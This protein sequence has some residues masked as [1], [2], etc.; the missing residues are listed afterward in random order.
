MRKPFSNWAK[1]CRFTFYQRVRR[2]KFIVITALVGLIILLAISLPII[3]TAQPDDED[4]KNEYLEEVSS[5]LFDNET[6]WKVSAE[7]LVPFFAVD[8]TLR[9]LTAKDM[10]GSK[11][12]LAKAAGASEKTLAIRLEQDG[13]NYSLI[14]I[15]PH[16]TNISEDTASAI[17]NAMAPYVHQLLIADSGASQVA[18]VLAQLEVSGSTEVAGEEMSLAA[19]MVKQFLPML[20]GLFMYMMLIL[21][22]QDLSQEVSSEKTSKL[23]ET[24]LTSVHPYA[25]V[26]GKVVAV[27]LVAVLQSMVW[28]GCILLGIFGGSFLATK[29]YPDGGSIITVVIEFIRTNIGKSAFSIPAIIMAVVIFLLGVLLFFCFAAMAGSMVSK[30]EDTASVQPLFVWPILICWMVPYFASMSGNEGVLAVCRYIPFTAPFCLPVDL[31]IGT[32][33]YLP[34]F[35][36]LVLILLTACAL[37]W[38]A[39]R[40]YKGMALYIGQKFSLKVVWGVIRGK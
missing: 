35:V 34:G 33:G 27:F 32:T 7:D 5:I 17:G 16:E 18:I 31:I 36:T 1:V 26:L 6:E 25:L 3:F 2:G 9:G 4:E 30:P 20:F 39:A 12:E 23:M 29:L 21:Y 28:L 10:Q 38:L 19:M 8:D 14:T 15:L 37:V 22:G 11:E 40:I 24:M 13:D